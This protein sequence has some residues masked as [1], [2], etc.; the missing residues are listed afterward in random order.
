LLSTDVNRR[1]LLKTPGRYWSAY[2]YFYPFSFHR[3]KEGAVVEIIR[4]Y[5][6]SA[7]NVAA[8][9]VWQYA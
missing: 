7:V 2:L 1:R 9:L 6:D 8:G 4:Y 5:K 3:I